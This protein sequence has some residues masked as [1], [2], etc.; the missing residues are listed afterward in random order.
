MS[1]SRNTGVFRC[2]LNGT[3]VSKDVC[4]RFAVLT[5]DIKHFKAPH[6]IVYGHSEGTVDKKFFFYRV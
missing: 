2:L 5:K 3:Q 1:I 6:D 4:C